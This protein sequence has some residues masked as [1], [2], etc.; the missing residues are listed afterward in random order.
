MFKKKTNVSHLG[1][2][3]W[4][5]GAQKDG[6]NHKNWIEERQGKEKMVVGGGS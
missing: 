4:R 6:K 3:S 5:R 2:A 1:C